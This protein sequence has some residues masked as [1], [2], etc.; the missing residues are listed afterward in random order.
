VES[1]VELHSLA[2]RYPAVV[3]SRW[4][5]DTAADHLCD[6]A[7]ALRPEALAAAQARGRARCLQETVSELCAEFSVPSDHALPRV[8][9]AWQAD[10][11]E[12][13]VSRPALL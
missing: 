6:A 9:D 5:A 7:A 12:R 1:A 11:T 10:S 3:N 8:T 4:F 2:W 13:C